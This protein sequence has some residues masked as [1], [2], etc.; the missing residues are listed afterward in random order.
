MPYLEKVCGT[1][2]SKLSYFRK[3]HSV[4]ASGKGCQIPSGNHS[5]CNYYF[6]RMG[7]HIKH[8]KGEQ[9]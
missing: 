8:M 1:K 6:V 2:L 9:L 4:F 3:Q 7:R 5:F